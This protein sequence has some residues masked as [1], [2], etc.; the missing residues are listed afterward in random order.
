MIAKAAIIAGR[1]E[2]QYE[3]DKIKVE[4]DEK[5]KQ[6]VKKD[7]K[8]EYQGVIEQNIKKIMGADGHEDNSF[9]YAIAK[10]KMGVKDRG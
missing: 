6:A 8:G 4:I 10:V 5:N 2:V 1:F 9:K 7:N 3:H